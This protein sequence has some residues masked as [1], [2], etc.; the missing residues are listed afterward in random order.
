MPVLDRLAHDR[1][2]V[3]ALALELGRRVAVDVGRRAHLEGVPQRAGLVDAL[4][5]RHPLV[6][7]GD[8][9]HDE[10]G[11]ALALGRRAP[12]VGHA[13]AAEQRDLDR[14]A[15]A[16][17][18]QVALQLAPVRRRAGSTSDRRSIVAHVSSP[19]C[20]YCGDRADHPAEQRE[21]RPSWPGRR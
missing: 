10:L 1:G 2:S 17:A 13:R 11:A 6:R 7:R 5:P 21:R 14:P 19:A 16:D 15:I 20:Q 9:D 3:V 8:E 12:L 4:E 18:V